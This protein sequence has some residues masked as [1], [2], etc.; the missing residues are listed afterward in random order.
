MSE[1]LVILT[2][3]QQ[4]KLLN[5]WNSRADNPPSLNDL[6]KIA[7]D[8]EDLDGRSKEGKA[9]KTFL[10]SRQI[11]PKKSYEYQAKGLIELSQEQ[12]E[13]VKKYGVT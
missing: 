11:R 8:R 9:V 10:A 3:E 12:K 13:Y 4:L 1:E 2:E 6:V 7:F 5:G